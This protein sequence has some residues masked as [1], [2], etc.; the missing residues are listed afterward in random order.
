MNPLGCVPRPY[1]G[2]DRINHPLQRVKAPSRFAHSEGV[3][4]VGQRSSVESVATPRLQVR[5]AG[6]DT[7]A[8]LWR[9]PQAAKPCHMSRRRRPRPGCRRRSENPGA[10]LLRR[11]RV[12]GLASCVE[13]WCRPGVLYAQDARPNCRHLERTGVTISQQDADVVAN[14]L[15]VIR[16]PGPARS[17]STQAP[18]VPSGSSGSWRSRYTCRL[19][20]RPHRSFHQCSTSI[21]V[22]K[23]RLTDVREVDL[24][25]A[26]TTR[27][28]LRER[29][30]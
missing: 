4:S 22:W 12:L 5:S 28:A 8:A 16:S 18:G 6:D 10:G 17:R 7:H 29:E 21:H 30:N 11:P 26:V 19:F 27:P 9:T 24:M 2:G 23:A 3:L 25:P 20:H 14:R 13:E 15:L 1:E